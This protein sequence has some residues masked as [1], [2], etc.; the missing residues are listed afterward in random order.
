MRSR[1]LA[2]ALAVMLLASAFIVSM[3]SAN[4]TASGPIA[5][6]SDADLAV[7]PGSG[8]AAD[9]YVISGLEINASGSGSAISI[10]N[11]TAHVLI[12]NCAVTNAD[13]GIYVNASNVTVRDNDVSQTNTCGICLDVEAQGDVVESNVIS[14]SVIDGIDVYGSGN[15]IA[16]NNITTSGSDGVYLDTSSG[17]TV[18]NNTITGSTDQGVLLYYSDTNSILNNSITDLDDQEGILLYYSNDNTVTDNIVNG[19]DYGVEAYHCSGG[20]ISGN[21]VDVG[22][23]GVDLFYADHFVADGNKVS[24]G[25]NH[26][27]YVYHANE[28]VISDNA[29]AGSQYG[30]NLQY[31]V[32]NSIS[33]NAVTG[34]F[35]GTDLFHS[36]GNTIGNNTFANSTVRGIWLSYSSDNSV[37]DNKVSNT[38]TA[39]IEMDLCY[40]RLDRNSLT[41]GSIVFSFGGVSDVAGLVKGMEISST[42]TVN[43]KPIY[44]AKSLDLSGASIPSGAGMVIALNVTHLSARSLHPDGGVAV[45]FSSNITVEGN[46]I[47]N[48]KGGIMVYSSPDSRIIGNHVTNGPTAISAESSARVTIANNTVSG[49]RSYGLVL[50]SSRSCTV[51]GNVVNSSAYGVRVSFSNNNV[52]ANNTLNGSGEGIYAS[53]SSGNLIVG[54]WITSSTGYG[55]E[56]SSGNRIYANMLV[57]NHGATSVFNASHAQARGSG[58]SWNTTS[59]GNYWGDWT[60]PDAN[61]DGIVDSPYLITAGDRDNFPLASVVHLVITSPTTSPYATNQGTVVVTGTTSGGLGSNVTRWHNALT[62]GSG[63]TGGASWSASVPLAP[64]TN[65]ITVTSTDST[66]YLSSVKTIVVAYSPGPQVAMTPSSGSTT[67]TNKSSLQVSFVITDA[68]PMTTANMSHY[69]GG[70][71]V[72]HQ[73]LGFVSGLTSYTGSM[74]LGLQSG[75]N[76]FY[77][78][79]N[80]SA[81]GSS[82][83]HLTAVVDTTPPQ[84][85]A[86]SPTGSGAPLST[87]VNATFSEQMNASSVSIT[88]GGI[89][90]TLAWSGNTAVFTPSSS[91]SYNTTYAVT[92]T[93]MD[94]AGNHVSTSWSFKTLKNEGTIS[95]TVKDSGGSPMAGA[96]VTLSNGMST[97]TDSAGHFEFLNVSSGSYTMTVTKSGYQPFTETVSASPGHTTDIG[98]VSPA[99]TPSSSPDYTL[100]L[101]ALVVVVI[102]VVLVAL[103]LVRR[104]KKAPKA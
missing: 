81:G 2:G 94:L 74:A 78:T 51:S 27:F 17:N 37:A 38:G 50:L 33:K 67:Y 21:T 82:T 87:S 99:A 34:G 18:S 53:S 10:E 41:N 95:G 47:A 1:M 39:A 9:P 32:N 72:G 61:H 48:A 104:R 14:D 91:L 43:G 79:F 25:G 30:I 42:N 35:Y 101:V 98:T 16:N 93:G 45:G 52:V 26:G 88:V 85:T 86:M 64:G 22:Y 8:T 40:G 3:S 20:V 90:G 75:A 60:A 80:D 31:S 65:A 77:F 83:V 6:S 66:G 28:N 29:V 46:V 62:G 92:V 59:F 44:F 97:T 70:A 7:F 49:S 23:I 102:V 36:T 54:N 24:G 13:F 11:T 19:G 58:S 5:I 73:P 103:V 71:L 68:E 56:C 12:R 69:V 55:I 15:L 4:A 89:S 100:V 57:G 96:S 84:V 63:T 76:L